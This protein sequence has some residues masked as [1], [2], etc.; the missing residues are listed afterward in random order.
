[1]PISR[2]E[3]ERDRVDSTSTVG[4]VLSTSPG[5]AFSREEIRQLL[6][7]A[8]ATAVTLENVDGE[9]AQLVSQGLVASRETEGNRWYVRVKRGFGSLRV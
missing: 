8:G 9:L 6:M 1:M 2:E 3:F 5:L 4:D 7:D